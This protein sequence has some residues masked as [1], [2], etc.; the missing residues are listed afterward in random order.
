MER[1]FYYVVTWSETNAIVRVLSDRFI[2]FALVQS[3]QL[4]IPPN[5]IAIVFPDLAVRV[6]VVV[7]KL[8][9][10]DGRAYPAK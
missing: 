2:P 1:S 5:H 4:N 7:R 8:F 10:R 9:G 6:Y 3:K